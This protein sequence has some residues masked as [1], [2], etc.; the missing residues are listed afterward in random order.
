MLSF[1]DIYG[2]QGTITF[3][4]DRNPSVTAG[5]PVRT[6]HVMRANLIG[7]GRVM[8]IRV[9]NP[10]LVRDFILSLAT[11]TTIRTRAFIAFNYN[12]SVSLLGYQNITSIVLYYE[13]APPPR[14]HSNLLRHARGYDHD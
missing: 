14:E 5:M 13:R 4:P 8:P 10:Q 12:P 3:Y 6:Y 11:V 7:N 2:H 1:R 9:E